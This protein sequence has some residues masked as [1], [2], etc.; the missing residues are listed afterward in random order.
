MASRTQ[1]AV[2]AASGAIAECRAL[3]QVSNHS[4]VVKGLFFGHTHHDQV[5]LAAAP[6]S[7]CMPFRRH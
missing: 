2:F 7:A 3:G 5:P 6:S 1:L 4:D